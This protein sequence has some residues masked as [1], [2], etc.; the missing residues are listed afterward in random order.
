MIVASQLAPDEDVPQGSEVA[1]L[2]LKPLVVFDQ[3]CLMGKRTQTSFF[4]SVFFKIIAKTGPVFSG[5]I[6]GSNDEQ[7]GL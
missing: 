4:L 7:K 5:R 1:R 6:E 3:S 2:G